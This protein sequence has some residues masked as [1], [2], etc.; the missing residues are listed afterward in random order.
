MYTAFS[1]EEVLSWMLYQLSQHEKFTNNIKTIITD[2]DH[3]FI[4]AFRSWMI[5]VKLDRQITL[6]FLNKLLKY[7]LNKEQRE[8][9]N[10]ML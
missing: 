3:S 10:N 2:E 6:N 7:G 5:R 9:A 1:K 4:N 8:I